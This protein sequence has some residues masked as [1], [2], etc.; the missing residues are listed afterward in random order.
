MQPYLAAMSWQLSLRGLTSW[1]WRT[2]LLFYLASC[3]TY[4]LST[5]YVYGGWST[6]HPPLLNLEEFWAAAGTKFTVFF[7]LT[8][9]VLY[10]ADRLSLHHLRRFAC[11]QVVALPAFVLLAYALQ[12]ALLDAFGWVFLFG[13]RLAIFNELLSGG[14]YV[15]QLLLLVVLHQAGTS[16]ATSRTVAQEAAE[17][18]RTAVPTD[19]LLATK[20]NR[21]VPVAIRDISHLIAAGNYTEAYRN[22]ER[23]LLPFGIGRA[24]ERLRAAGF[25]RVHRSHIVRLTAVRGIYRQGRR[26]L[27]RLMDGSEL[28]CG[29]TYVVRLKELRG[30]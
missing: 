14:F 9:L 6:G 15:C 20:G 8:L 12:R 17:P 27:I 2:L 5:W 22:G 29:K 30:G 13:G 4:Y 28:A 18:P 19:I 16:A 24:E 25:M 21:Q 7:V 10:L 3:L 26:Y 1:Q 23:Y 11:F